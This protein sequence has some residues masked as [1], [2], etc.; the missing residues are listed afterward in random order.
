MAETTSMKSLVGAE[1]A[2]EA[3][4]SRA[5]Q[6]PVTRKRAPAKPKAPPAPDRH[7]VYVVLAVLWSALV[8][9]AAAGGAAAMLLGR[10]DESS[11]IPAGV[12]VAVSGKA[13]SAFAASHAAPVYW[14]G[15]LPS[16][17]LELTTSRAGTFVR[18]LPAGVQAGD[19]RPTFTTIATYPLPNAYATA[20]GRRKQPGMASRKT[21]GG[22]LAV[23]NRDKP[24]SV[25]V[26]FPGVSHL[27]EVY[28]QKARDAR[29]LALSGRLRPVS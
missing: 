17:R 18:Y 3:M 28:A 16:R 22:G 5:T 25:Y 21:P 27:V 7:R 9:A 19:P 14:A 13:L 23:W 10:D 11:A 20:A 6:H 4:S 29:M 12:P 2:P 1:A 24:T 8:V 26:A 15:G